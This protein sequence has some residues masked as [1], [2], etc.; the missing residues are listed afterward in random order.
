MLKKSLLGLVAVLVV[1]AAAILLLA[2]RQPDEFRIER[3][4]TISAPP[5]KIVPHIDNFQQWSAWSPWEHLD[6]A[7]QRSFS[8]P[9][10]GKGSIYEWNGND[11]V[12]QGRMEILE[13][14]T[15]KVTIKLD[16]YKPMEANNVAEFVLQPKGDATDVIWAMY[17]PMPFISKVVG[18]FMDMDKLVGSDFERGLAELKK[19]SEQ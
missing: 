8:G 19:V 4:I 15:A 5:D 9:P 6:P 13:S 18:V 12:G 16:F 11:K 10:A 17:G 2:S 7:M 3:S 14:S 1:A